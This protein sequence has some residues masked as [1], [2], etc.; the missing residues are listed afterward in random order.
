[1]SFLVTEPHWRWTRALNVIKEKKTA[2]A[3][4]GFIAENRGDKALVAAVK[5]LSDN[6]ATAVPGHIIGDAF[7]LFA[8]DAFY[9][10]RQV[11]EAMIL[12]GCS[13]DEIFEH[14]L[15]SADGVDTYESLF[16]NIRPYLTKRALLTAVLFKGAAHAPVN[17]LS[18]NEIML[19]IA[20][21][22]N[23]ESLIEYITSGGDPVM[24][25]KFVDLTKSVMRKKALDFVLQGSGEETGNEHLKLVLDKKEEKGGN[26][27][28]QLAKATA[29]FMAG[30]E[31]TVADPTKQHNLELPAREARVA[32]YAGNQQ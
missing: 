12:A 32:D 2:T 13:N 24:D 9:S 17:K 3:R 11:L 5:Y 7:R 6:G 8:D 10:I 26:S 4:A 29:E 28:D 30:L 14:T 1:M 20:F 16:F 15:I 23:K 21:L 25:Q 31:L 22:G 18:K 19:R 27:G